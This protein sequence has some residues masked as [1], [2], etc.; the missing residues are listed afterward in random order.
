LISGKN[1]CFCVGAAEKLS[2][3]DERDGGKVFA[4]DGLGRRDVT[5]I[6][7]LESR[8]KRVCFVVHQKRL[9][10]GPESLCDL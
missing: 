2:A 8:E 1:G 6:K 4:G 9:F 10:E 3:I 5:E 7:G